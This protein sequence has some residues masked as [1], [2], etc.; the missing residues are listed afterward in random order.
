MS[1]WNKIDHGAQRWV[2]EQDRLAYHLM[3]AAY[4]ADPDLQ[5]Q[6]INLMTDKQRDLAR[7]AKDGSWKRC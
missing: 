5:K 7:K 1:W 3:H 2:F 6:I 4:E